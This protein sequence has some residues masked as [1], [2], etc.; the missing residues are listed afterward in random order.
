[1]A[2]LDES[3]LTNGRIETSV[4]KIR[5]RYMFSSAS[6]YLQEQFCK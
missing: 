2:L 6:D 5:H 4:S 3:F 1:M